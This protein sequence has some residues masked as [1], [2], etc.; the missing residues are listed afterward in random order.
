[1]K[2]TNRGFKQLGE[3]SDRLEVLEENN[4]SNNNEEEDEF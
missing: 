2:K 4:F 1:V 3:I